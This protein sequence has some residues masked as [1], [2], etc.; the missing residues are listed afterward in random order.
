MLRDWGKV[1]S[2]VY[3]RLGSGRNGVGVFAIRPIPKGT[4]PFKHCDPFGGVIK[5]S[6]DE[7]TQ[8]HAPES[9]KRMVRDFCALQDGVY[10]VPDYGVDAIDKS[11][12]LNHSDR[13]NMTTTDKGETFVAKRKINLGEELTISYDLFNEARHFARR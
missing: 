13:S 12:Y 11:Y 3:V 7:L 1:S 2:D 8:S 5:V 4:D 10:Y 9:A 6:K